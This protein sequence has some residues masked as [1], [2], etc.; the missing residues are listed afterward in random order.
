MCFHWHQNL[1]LEMPPIPPPPENPTD[2]DGDRC[3]HSN[4]FLVSEIRAWDL[5]VLWMYEN[6]INFLSIHNQI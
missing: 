2:D 6:F 5:Q 3:N 1:L 4:I